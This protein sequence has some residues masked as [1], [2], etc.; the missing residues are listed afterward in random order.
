MVRCGCGQG[1]EDWCKLNNLPARV[2]ELAAIAFDEWRNKGEDYKNAACNRRSA[3]DEENINRNINEGRTYAPPPGY[4]GYVRLSSRKI[5]EVLGLVVEKEEDNQ[6]SVIYTIFGLARVQ[7][8]YE[9]GTW[10]KT[11]IIEDDEENP[12]QTTFSDAFSKRYQV[13]KCDKISPPMSTRVISSN[14]MEKIMLCG[15]VNWDNDCLL[16]DYLGVIED[17]KGYLEYVN[18]STTGYLVE[19]GLAHRKST[20]ALY[21]TLLK[22]HGAAVKNH[23]WVPLEMSFYNKDLGRTMDDPHTILLDAHYTDP[24]PLDNDQ[25][26]SRQV[27]PSRDLMNSSNNFRPGFG[28]GYA[29]GEEEQEETGSMYTCRSV[30][31]VIW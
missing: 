10:L 21:F 12:M 17:R 29:R 3:N 8:D 13:Y 11:S 18:A 5:S 28:L 1:K 25:F 7:S 20:G 23:N 2:E 24:R 14:G 30:L 26:S 19:F 31:E 9:L 6:V 15:I 27:S 16:N 4:N 22:Y